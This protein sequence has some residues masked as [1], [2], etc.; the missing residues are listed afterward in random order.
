LAASRPTPLFAPRPDLGYS[1]DPNL[2]RAAD[3]QR[4]RPDDVSRKTGAVKVL[5]LS[6]FH[7]ELVRGGAQQI[8]Y[9]LFEGLKAAPD[10]EPVLLAAIDPSFGAF[11]K[12][13]ARITGFDGRPNE[14][15]Y[16]SRDYDYVWH[17]TSSALLIEAY[18]E[19]LELVRPDIVHFHHFLLFGVDLITLTRKTLP[20]A[21]IVFTFHEFM[22]ICAADGQLVRALDRSLC[23]RATP[24]R[25]HQCFPDRGPEH[26]FLRERW[27]KRHLDA[28]DHFTTPTQ[29]MIDHYDRWGVARDRITHVTNGQKSY[30]GEI[31]SEYI[32]PQRNR[33]GF[34]GQ[35]VDNKGLN[36]LLEAVSMLRS[37]GFTDFSVELNGD[38]LRYASA[39]RRSEIETFLAQEM[40]R[41]LD[42]RIV[43][44]NGSYEVSQ[45]RQ[46]MA[47]VDWCVVPSVW[48]EAFGLV[49]SEAWMFGRPVIC[50]DV[51]AMAERVH[52]EQ[53]GL[54]FNAGNARALADA[55]RH[56]A[57]TKGLWRSLADRINPPPSR[58]TMV[59]G[60]LEVYNRPRKTL[61]GIGAPGSL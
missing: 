7:P 16:L 37:G 10:V 60:F 35:F 5:L 12:P 21:K 45:L 41:P 25:C 58:K 3:A 44:H 52:H 23:D 1:T 28:V 30:G 11:Y 55:I 4:V 40:E 47:R 20:E 17:K 36:V 48:Y 39:A 29:F 33:F 59:D 22:S 43:T 6:I 18:V 32:R 15:L 34:F 19:F 42:E 14:F 53:N 24:V 2:L 57:T 8:C 51:G 26:F 31:T 61:D 46:R 13:G 9:E 27:M 54:L 50:S 38:N 49:I 56:A